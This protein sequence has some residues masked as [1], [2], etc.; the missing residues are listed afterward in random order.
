MQQKDVQIYLV[1]LATQR[2]VTC[3]NPDSCR[4]LGENLVS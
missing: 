3:K 2:V 1:G 4:A